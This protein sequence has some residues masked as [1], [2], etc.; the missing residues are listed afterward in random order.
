MRSSS[1]VSSNAA[2]ARPCTTSATAWPPSA[3]ACSHARSV[4]ASGTIVSTFTYPDEDTTARLVLRGEI[5]KPPEIDGW[6]GYKSLDVI[7][8]AQEAAIPY[9]NEM[10]MMATFVSAVAAAS[11]N[12]G[13]T[14]KGFVKRAGSLFQTAKKKLREFRLFAKDKTKAAR[15]KLTSAMANIVEQVQDGLELALDEAARQTTVPD[16]TSDSD[17]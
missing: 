7:L 9:P 4:S 8:T 16:L 3:L 5:R 15:M 17:V 11:K 12:V 1:Y 10:N 6:E 13:T 14:L 2:S